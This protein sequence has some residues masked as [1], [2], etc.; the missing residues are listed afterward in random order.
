MRKSNGFRDFVSPVF[1]RP[2]L[3]G[4]PSELIGAIQINTSPQPS[5]AGTSGNIV[6]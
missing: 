2:P 3:Y 6:D 4:R 1:R 5:L